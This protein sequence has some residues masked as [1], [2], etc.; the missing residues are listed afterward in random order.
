MRY[1][2]KQIA[3]ALYAVLAGV[4]AGARAQLPATDIWVADLA[5]DG[6]TVRIDTPENATRHPGYD[7]QPS[8]LPDGS[9]FLFSAA[10]PGT[11]TDV[12]R[13]DAETGA[14][15]R[16]TDTPES[17]YSPTPL[18]GGF[19]AVR[20]EADST[21]RLW[22]FDADGGSPRCVMTDVDSVGYFVWL[23]PRTVAVFVVGDPH[24]LRR[25]D[26]AAQAETIVARDIGRC[27]LR[28]PG[29]RDVTF[30]ARDA[31]GRYSF[32]RL[33][34]ADSTP[35]PLIA[36]A[37]EGQDAAW[38]GDTLLATTGTAVFA[39]R[40]FES[41][42][43]TRVADAAKWRLHGLTRIAASPDGGTLALVCEE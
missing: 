19:C 25:V 17:E 40:P 36:G 15:G 24:T 29:T 27:L 10:D 16:V 35:V 26:V 7:N 5:V 39:A 41:G 1:S 42:V 31:D 32:F 11:G 30:T 4:A 13:W 9:G 21:Q 3:I 28:V 20:V 37:G 38:V 18:D 8:F 6:G 14:V 33:P 22:R 12:F 43:W 2:R 34:A 23:D